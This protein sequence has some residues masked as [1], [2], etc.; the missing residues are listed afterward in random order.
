MRQ[1]PWVRAAAGL[2]Q[3]ADRPE[4]AAEPRLGGSADGIRRRFTQA[5]PTVTASEAEERG[6]GRLRGGGDYRGNLSEL[7]EIDGDAGRDEP[8]WTEWFI[9]YPIGWTEL[10]P[11]ER[12]SSAKFY[13]FFKYI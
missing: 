12:G 3:L 11:S 10:M 5:D 6:I 7:L 2:P 8:E 13:P 9:G 4:G 1:M